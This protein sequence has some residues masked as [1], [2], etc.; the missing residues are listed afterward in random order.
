MHAHFGASAAG[1][2]PKM[3]RHSTACLHA[4]H[5][6]CGLE[7]VRVL[8]GHASPSRDR[9]CDGRRLQQCKYKHTQIMDM[10]DIGAATAQSHC[11]DEQH[12]HGKS[13]ANGAPTNVQH[14]CYSG[15]EALWI[16]DRRFSSSFPGPRRLGRRY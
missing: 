8:V 9:L 15:N 7:T 10:T 3:S 5:I 13:H 12:T 4:P 6:L 14:C 16:C 2:Q 11:F 1:M